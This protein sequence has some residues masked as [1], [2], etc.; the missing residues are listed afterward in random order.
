MLGSELARQLA[1]AGLCFAPTGSETDIGDYAK[2]EQ[3]ASGRRFD[4]IINC[5]AYTAVDK[6]EDEPETAR[7]TN[8][9]GAANLAGI[10]AQHNAALVHVS[11]DYVFDG[12]AAAPI[13]E[14]AAKRPIGVYG[15]TKSDGEDAITAKLAEHYI[16][17]TAWL[18]GTRGKN[19][20]RTMLRLM[21]EKPQ[22]RVVSDQYGTPTNCATLAGC[23]V[24]IV[25][26]GKGG[27]PYGIYH[28]TDEGM[29]SWY[30]FALEIQ[31]L[32]I[33]A[34]LIAGNCAVS[35]CSTAEYPVRAQRPAYSVLDK[36][37]IQSALG[38]Q[39]P[40]WQDSLAEFISELAHRS[41]K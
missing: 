19:F 32:G 10:A 27:A 5:A 15:R 17:R 21:Q 16:L 20:V 8:C 26:E 39:L 23:I 33:A 41:S 4:W 30:E 38:I 34:G 28:V 25:L 37:K 14:S 31:R 11:T 2:V 22:L 18:Y 6:A 40:Q 7:R 3:F 9:D 29:A 12:T 36:G 24:R 35:P 13:A 1:A